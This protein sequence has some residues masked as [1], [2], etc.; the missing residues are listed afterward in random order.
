MKKKAL[1]ISDTH[2]LTKEVLAVVKSDNFDV[3]FH[4]GDYCVD[5]TQKPFNQMVLVRGNNDRGQNI[6]LEQMTTW[7]G[8]PIFIA[9]GHTYNVYSSLLGLQYRAEE[10]GAKVVLFG[11]THFPVATSDGGIVY[12]NPGSLKQPRGYSVPTY[13]TLTVQ[14][15]N[16]N[17]KEIVCTYYD[18]EHQSIEALSKRFIL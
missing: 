15:L 10:L 13:A 5:E 12:L 6:P 14:E 1:I 16:A 18:L 8:I 3:I 2:G 17:R 4:C 9:H 11:H 7:E